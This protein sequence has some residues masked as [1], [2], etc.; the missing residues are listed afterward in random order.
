MKLKKFRR[1]YI[2]IKFCA[3]VFIAYFLVY[4]ALDLIL[5]IYLSR[6]EK[7]Y[8]E[9]AGSFE[10]NYP[11]DEGVSDP[12]FTGD[13]EKIIRESGFN[14]RNY[15][16][17]G[18]NAG[19]D[20]F[21]QMNHRFLESA[22]ET[23][24]GSSTVPDVVLLENMESLED[25]A[26]SIRE[27]L[28]RNGGILWTEDGTREIDLLK[29]GQIGEWMAAEAVRCSSEGRAGEAESFAEALKRLSLS[30]LAARSQDYWLTACSLAQTHS[31][32]V[33][34]TGGSPSD[35]SGQ[36][37]LPYYRALRGTILMQADRMIKGAGRMGK[38]HYFKMHRR[39]GMVWR[40]YGRL[41]FRYSL[42]REIKARF[43]DYRDSESFLSCGNLKPATAH[44]M[45]RT[46]W[47][48]NGGEFRMEDM[49]FRLQK[50]Y[51][52]FEFT[53]WILHLK[54]GTHAQRGGGFLN[55]PAV[56]M[57]ERYE[58]DDLVIGYE[59]PFEMK[60]HK[61]VID[62]PNYFRLKKNPGEGA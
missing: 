43:R 35:I 60:R 15:G 28:M 61:G 47:M 25:R 19:I 23:S 4:F 34:K 30:L 38:L 10:K 18:N 55:C 22:L 7:E 51:L 31:G 1:L 8:I 46:F 27:V 6:L 62:I 58:G 50:L 21:F 36:D 13:L 40:T 16:S 2:F 41:W 49:R 33:R 17:S 12:H 59:T 29:V 26:L 52:S 9:L 42:I 44:G 56:K 24:D 5:G 45:K 32:I 14:L 57:V 11:Q 37:I 20:D 54:N 3:A 39:E 53:K 48:M